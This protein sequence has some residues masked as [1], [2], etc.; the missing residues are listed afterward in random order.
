MKILVIDELGASVDWCMQC[1]NTGHEVRLWIPKTEG[2]RCKIGDGIVP[3]VVEWKAHA[4]WADLIFMTYNGED[5]LKQIEPYHKKGYPIFGPNLAGSDLEVKRDV[6]QQVFK[7]AG[8]KILPS[9]EF[10]DYNEAIKYV[11]DHM[12]RFVSKPDGDDVDKALSYLSSSPQD[13]IFMLERWRDK[14]SKEMKK[15]VKQKFILQKFQPGLEMA[16]GGWFG[17]NGWSQW[18]LENFEHKKHMPGDN[19]VNTGEMGTCMMYKKKSKLADILLKPLT[20]YLHSID[21]RGF[22]DVSAIIDD[23]GQ[24]WPLEATARLGWPCFLIQTA[25]HVGDPAQWMLDL[26]NG[27]DTLEV[28]DEIATGV[29]IAIPDFPYTQYTGRDTEGF[30][31]Y[32]CEPLLCEDLHL[33]AAMMGEIPVEEDGKI[34]RK[35]G[36]VTCGD[37]PAVATGTDYSVTGSK[38]R[39][40][41]AIKKIEIPN[42]PEWRDDIGERL[43][44]QLPKLQDLGYAE[45]WKY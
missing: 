20:S 19:G 29:V 11:E 25:L 6:G 45:G 15:V 26:L 1:M 36:Y 22:F 14:P 42:S 35:K 5:L 3:K 8:L 16:V 23:D 2:K 9:A 33:S 4:Q 44:K 28:L 37:L 38:N 18:F 13:M 24:P 7:K 21:Y 39:A 31:I 30:P 43:E 10:D 27:E 40:M 34:V 17:K 12:E 32:N 41:R